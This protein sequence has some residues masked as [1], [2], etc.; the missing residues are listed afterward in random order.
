MAIGTHGDGKKIRL[1][2]AMGV[3]VMIMGVIFLIDAE[4][5]FYYQ[6]SFAVIVAGLLWFQL[7]IHLPNWIRKK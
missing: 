2:P 6:A 3:F 4:T 5:R 7:A 1:Q